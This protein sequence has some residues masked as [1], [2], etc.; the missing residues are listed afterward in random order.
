MGLMMAQQELLPHPADGARAGSG[1]LPC[2]GIV[3]TGDRSLQWSEALVTARAQLQGMARSI[4]ALM[5]S[6]AGRL[7]KRQRLRS[8]GGWLGGMQ[9]CAALTRR[10]T[11]TRILPLM[12]TAEEH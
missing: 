2:L 9:R 11:S 8:R 6:T 4:S 5:S 10:V 7:K 3:S 12:R 1:A